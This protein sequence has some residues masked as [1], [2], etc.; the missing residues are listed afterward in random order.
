MSD[1]PNILS[2]WTTS[3]KAGY[4]V[5]VAALLLKALGTDAMPARAFLQERL[6]D[7]PLRE[8]VSKGQDYGIRQCVEETVKKLT[9][10]RNSP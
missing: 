5:L 2:A 7:G 8:K 3:R 4:Q 6:A 9:K 10:A 1:R